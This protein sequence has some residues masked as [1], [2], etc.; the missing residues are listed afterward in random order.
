[1]IGGTYGHIGGA[2]EVTAEGVV[3]AL[4]IIALLEGDDA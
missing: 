1:M 3:I 2:V 4:D